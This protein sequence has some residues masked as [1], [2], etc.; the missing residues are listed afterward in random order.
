MMKRIWIVFAVVSIVFSC[1]GC[2]SANKMHSQE[3]KP[4]VTERQEHLLKYFTH[5]TGEVYPQTVAI[6]IPTE[7]SP[8]LMDSIAVF[9]NGKLYAFFDNGEERHLTYESVYS[10]DVRHLVDHYCEAYAPFLLAD[11]T[12]EH[13][14]ATDCLE[15]NLVAQTNAYVT[16]EVVEAFIGEG[17]EIAKEWVT[18][19]KSDGHRLTEVIS[20]PEMLHF[21]RE[22]PDLRSE[23]V[24]ED[25]LHHGSEADSL[26]DIVCS[27]GLLNDSI[28]HQYV[29]APGIFEDVTY[30]LNEI[31][32]YL[33]KEAQRLIDNNQ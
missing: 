10:M 19:V 17:V 24:W 7:G 8:S 16:Y 5:M 23:D 21:Y 14:F 25:V 9:L 4:L 12:D 32:P 13:M 30:P 2:Q 18:F 15:M 31:A 6:D 28:T 29:Y 27:V 3:G 20:N 26:V 1:Y 33:S 11:S 22:H